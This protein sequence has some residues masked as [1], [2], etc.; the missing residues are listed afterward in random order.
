MSV[1]ELHTGRSFAAGIVAFVL[2]GL[3]RTCDQPKKEQCTVKSDS[4]LPGL[5]K[6]ESMRMEADF[7]GTAVEVIFTH[8]GGG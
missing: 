1:E 8:G 7:D 6:L 4:T 3:C 2:I 5:Q